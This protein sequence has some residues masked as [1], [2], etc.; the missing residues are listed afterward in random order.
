MIFHQADAYIMIPDEPL[1]AVATTAASGSVDSL[2]GQKQTQIPSSLTS[3][4]AMKK[5]T[6]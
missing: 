4:P 5:K 1:G 3:Y 2:P 6:I